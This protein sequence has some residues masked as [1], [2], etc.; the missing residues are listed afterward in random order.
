MRTP[1]GQR[2]LGGIGASEGIAIGKAFLLERR[3]L[4][5]KREDLNAH[6]VDAEVRRFR[7]SVAESMARL[8]SL[9]QRS[10]SLGIGGSASVVA[11][12]VSLL[13]D[14]W[15]TDQTEAL[16]ARE[17]V[18]AEWALERS[19]ERVRDLFRTIEDD[20]IRERLQDIEFVAER[21]F[22]QL[23]GVEIDHLHGLQPDHIVFAH[24]LSPVDGLHLFRR[25]VS[26]FVTEVGAKTS[27]LGIMA[28]THGVPAV[29]GLHGA[30]DEVQE[31]D[32]VL[33]DGAS[34]A[35]AICPEP[36]TLRSQGW[37][38]CASTCCSASRCPRSLKWSS[39]AQ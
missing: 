12:Y 4:A 28:R 5:I 23:L 3:S 37:T 13:K 6:E 17:G 33:V 38:S 15:I 36:D 35:V 30:L 25:G 34:G 29:V 26:G 22:H 19:L 39:R 10:E 14:P 1:G 27:H 7:A 9:R 11:A 16:I 32:L 31:G 2:I 20:T 24:Q 21:L 18:N 8:D